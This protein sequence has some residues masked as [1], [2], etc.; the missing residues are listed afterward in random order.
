MAGGLSPIGNNPPAQ[1]DGELW[2][3]LMMDL[4]TTGGPGATSGLYGASTIDI[5]EMGPII[6]QLDSALYNYRPAGA[7]FAGNSAPSGC[8]AAT[9]LR[10]ELTVAAMAFP[11]SGTLQ[12]AMCHIPINTTIAHFNFLAGT[13]GDAGPTNQ[14]MGLY[15]SNRNLL[16]VSAD[17]TSTAITASVVTSYAVAKVNSTPQSPSGGVSTNATSFVTYYTGRY[18]L[19]LLIATSNA[20]TF[21]ASGAVVAANTVVPIKSG[22]SDTGLTSPSAIPHQATTITPSADIPYFFCT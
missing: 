20:P 5:T 1:T 11:G 7:G 4:G 22:S 13:T 18:Y 9:T 21:T 19:G 10:E 14:W 12:L 8:L 6:N 16:A 3:N 2:R 15:D 17:A